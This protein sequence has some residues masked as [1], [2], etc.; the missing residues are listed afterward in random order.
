MKLLRAWKAT[1][2]GLAISLVLTI[3]APAYASNVAHPTV[4]SETAA[5]WTPHL[6]AD[7]NHSHPV[8]YSITQAGNLMVVGGKFTSVQNADRT[9]TYRRSHIMAFHSITGAV[10][11]FAPTFD[12]Q[13]WSVLGD[14][15]SI[16]VGGEFKTVNG[17]LRP[18]LAKLNAITGALDPNFRPTFTGG[19]V[20]DIALVHGQLI[21]GG[22]FRRKL[23][24]LN[25][26]TGRPTNYINVSV[27]G[28][29]PNT[30]LPEVFR[31]DVS[32][33]GKKL[34]AVGNFTIV[35]GNPHW[36]V[37]MMDLGST[38]SSLSPWNYLP[39]D[40]PCHAQ[41]IPFYQMYV[42]DVDF[43]PD[44]SYFVLA[45]TGGFPVTEADRFTVLCDTAVRF[46]SNELSP[47]APTWMN[48]TGGDT[49]HSVIVSGAAVYVQ[50]HSRWLDNP[51]GQDFAGPGAVSRPGGGAIDPVTGM[52]LPWNPVM[53]QLKGGYQMLVT[54]AGVWFA[55]D[56]MRFGGKYRRGIRFAP[57]P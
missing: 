43:A 44:S 49:L 41:H 1:S 31:F 51:Y 2:C 47:T 17:V 22:T 11:D 13:I 26:V 4:V 25:P 38:S 53:P 15:D 57:L 3:A 54:N 24:A 19:R 32:P 28:P 8:A 55:T 40:R 6:A 56:G 20:T 23:V 39:L 42:R 18:A 21:V 12:R 45:S 34:V 33:D 7:D 35:G 14:G 16:Y 10:T 30:T 52:A 48:K 50:G 27:A 36:R 5:T 9:V 46:E 37:F 29:L